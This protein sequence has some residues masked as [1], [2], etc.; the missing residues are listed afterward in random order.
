MRPGNVRR[1]RYVA[2]IVANLQTVF[3]ELFPR[4][5]QIGRPAREDCHLSAGGR[6][7]PRDGEP[8]SLAA[9][10]NGSD[11]IF[12]RNLHAGPG[13]HLDAFL[14]GKVGGVDDA[15]IVL[16]AHGD[17]DLLSIRREERLVRRTADIGDVLDCVGRGVDERHR[18]RS[19]R[20]DGERL[21]VG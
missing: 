17:P 9:A 4:G 7:L 21:V 5:L 10:G 20:D 19:D 8:D 18:I 2:D 1:L 12:Y 3:R 14:L 16:A 11:A 6:K 13:R 15:D